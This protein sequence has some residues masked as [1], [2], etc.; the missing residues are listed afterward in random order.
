MTNPDP[1]LNPI[2]VDSEEKER[3][4]VPPEMPFTLSFWEKIQLLCIFNNLSD[5]HLVFNM[6]M[7]PLRCFF[8]CK[9]SK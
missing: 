3:K 5:A 9:K 8:C 7:C 1:I 6:R 4:S 2:L